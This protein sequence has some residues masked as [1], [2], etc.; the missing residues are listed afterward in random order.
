MNLSEL[1][2]KYYSISI[3][4]MSKNSGKTTV[5]NRL[6]QEFS[7][8]K[9]VLGLTSVGRDGESVDL[10]TVTPKPEI[11]AP[12]GTLVAAAKGLMRFSTTTN[13]ILSATGISTPLGEV[14]VFRALSSGFVQIAG[15]SVTEQISLITGL[16][17]QFG[18]DKA[19]I[20]GA[21]SRR[22]LSS[23]AVSQATVLSAGASYSPDMS[24][25]ARDTAFAAKMLTLPKS[26]L[27]FPAPLRKYIILAEGEFVH[28]DENYWAF[29]AG[30]KPGAVYFAGGLTDN[31]LKP[32]ISKN[33]DI[34]G[35]EFAVFDGSRIF[36]TKKIYQQLLSKGAVLKVTHEVNLVAVTVNPVSAY[37]YA[38]DP[39]EFKN[40]VR[41]LVNV[42][43]IDVEKD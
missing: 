14:V 41:E 40:T 12:K 5:L 34:S 35:V 21:I 24:E 32:L 1:L 38:F 13:E 6:V 3:I 37:G 43:V 9:L 33:I 31:L 8:L 23:A 30:K 39:V 7:A 20:D 18:A 10:V 19:I 27:I 11:F 26:G 28:T 25:V 42:P 36:L 22:S 17:G 29:F 2:S 4:G 16:F 15:P